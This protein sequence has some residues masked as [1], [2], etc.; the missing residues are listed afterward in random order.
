MLDLKSRPV[1]AEQVKYDAIKTREYTL[2]LLNVLH[3]AE[4]Y[5]DGVRIP[6][7][8]Y[9]RPVVYVYAIPWSRG[10]AVF[11]SESTLVGSY[12]WREQPKRY[13]GLQN[14]VYCPRGVVG[15]WNV[16]ISKLES[17]VRL[18]VEPLRKLDN[19]RRKRAYKHYW[20]WPRSVVSLAGSAESTHAA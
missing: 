9:G 13:V 5:R 16:A 17:A 14:P 18:T 12:S 4:P 1:S 11:A 6:V 3:G 10:W 19:A 8:I 20:Y 15:P 2:A 7:P